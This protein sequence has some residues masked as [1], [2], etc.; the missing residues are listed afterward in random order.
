V[1]PE[2]WQATPSDGSILKDSANITLKSLDNTEEIKV[3]ICRGEYS[4]GHS[5]GTVVTVTKE[6]TLL[7]GMSAILFHNMDKAADGLQSLSQHIESVRNG[8]TYDIYTS[9]KNGQKEF[10]QAFAELIRDWKWI[11]SKQTT[12]G[13]SGSAKLNSF[14]MVDD[15]NGWAIGNN[16]AILI[17]ADGGEH[18]TDETPKGVQ[19]QGG[20]ISCFYNSKTAWIAQYSEGKNEIEIFHTTDSGATWKETNIQNPTK[21]GILLN[22]TSLEFLNSK[23]GWLSIMP[24]H[25][26]NSAPGLLLSTRDGGEH[27]SLVSE[28]GG[29]QQGTN[30]PMPFG[31]NVRFSSPEQG[32]IVGAQVN[33]GTAMLYHSENS[34]RNWKKIDLP[35]PRGIEDG[36]VMAKLPMFFSEQSNTGFIPAIFQPTDG[37]TIKFRTIVYETTDNGRTWRGRQLPLEI[38]PINSVS[39]YGDTQHWFIWNSDSSSIPVNGKLYRSENSG[40]NWSEI[41]LDLTLTTELGENETITEMQFTSA[42]SGWARLEDQNHVFAKLLKTMDGG[43][44]WKAMDV[45]LVSK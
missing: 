24:D 23:S 41:K 5:D 45:E 26:M 17:T 6:P 38:S 3:G 9:L 20:S 30:N 43:Q 44:N 18:W 13:T 7:D 29:F 19:L 34:G 4:C 42:L 39:A 10:P 28:T 31:G 12:T 37:E 36:K 8:Y 40:R 33:T 2:G 35:L 25:G 15:L 22:L 14:R 1:L 27:W 16:E 21:S 32:W 11:Q